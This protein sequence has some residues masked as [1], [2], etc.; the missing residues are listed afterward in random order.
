MSSPLATV[1]SIKVKLGLLVVASVV[2]AMV[3]SIVGYDS[4]VPFCSRSR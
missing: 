2:V 4:G 1:G 3:V